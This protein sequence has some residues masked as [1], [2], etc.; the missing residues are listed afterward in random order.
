M[1]AALG[2]SALFLEESFGTTE[3]RFAAAQVFQKESFNPN[4]E[5]SQEDRLALCASSLILSP[6]APKPQCL[7]LPPS[8]LLI[9]TLLPLLPSSSSS[10]AS[11]TRCTSRQQLA[12]ATMRTSRGWCS[13]RLR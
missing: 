9:E 7:L 13:G 8:F 10:A 11:Q 5:P 1:A 2:D 3:E 4:E 6:P 12:T